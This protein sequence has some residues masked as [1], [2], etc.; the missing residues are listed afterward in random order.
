MGKEYGIAMSDKEK[1]K[2]LIFAG[3]AGRRMNARSL[4]KQF[5]QVYGKPVIIHT[6]EHFEY[7]DMID[8]IDIV[9]LKNWISELKGMLN[10]FGIRKVNIIVP[11]GSTGHKSI[12]EGLKAMRPSTADKDIVLIHDGVRPLINDDLITANIEA[13][14]KYGNA[15]TCEAARESVVV[16]T[17]GKD[18]QQVPNRSNMYVAKAPQS[19]RFGEVYEAYGQAEAAGYQTIDSSHLYGIQK[20]HMHLLHSTKNN[21]KITEPADFYIYKALYEAMEAQQIYGF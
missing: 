15:I 5:L 13:V 20:R 2:V 9:C 14:R 8:E 7:H 19:F 4:P 16:S 11:G 21:M 10:R 17:N 18:I 1:V 6:L 3:G 12:W